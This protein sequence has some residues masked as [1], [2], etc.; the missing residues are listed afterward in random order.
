MC[1][2]IIN[3]YNKIGIP[4][5]E[6]QLKINDICLIT[7][8]L[9]TDN[10]ASNTRVRVTKINRHFITALTLT[11]KHNRI[12][13]IPRIRFRFRMD[14]R[15]SY[16]MMRTQFPLRLASQSQT[17]HRTLVDCTEMPFAHGHL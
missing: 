6:L 15:Q 3:A 10:I 13:L 14:Y 5:H 17:L 16:S 11:E 8:A 2:E 9:M 4:P 1:P 7:R 12:V